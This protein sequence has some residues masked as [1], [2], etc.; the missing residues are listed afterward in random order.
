MEAKARPL[1]NYETP[2]GKEPFPIWLR[3]LKDSKGRARIR[4]RL[5]RI[6]EKGHFGDCHPV[7]NGVLELRFHFSP[8][9]RVYIGEDGDDVILLLG[10][11][12]DTQS[13]DITTAKEYWKDYHG[14]EEEETE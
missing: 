12:K 8:G 14:K 2:N 3:G 6:E 10:G 7:G 11:N 13:K 4:T 5:D 1:F 9:Y